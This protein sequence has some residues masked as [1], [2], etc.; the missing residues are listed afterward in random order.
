M[1]GHDSEVM[2][3]SITSLGTGYLVVVVPQHPCAALGPGWRRRQHPDHQ[4]LGGGSALTGGLSLQGLST[5]LSQYGTSMDLAGLP[6]CVEGA[7][8]ALLARWQGLLCGPAA[9]SDREDLSHS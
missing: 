2:L 7:L 9:D 5:F 8:E 6:S 3:G 4:L 1:G